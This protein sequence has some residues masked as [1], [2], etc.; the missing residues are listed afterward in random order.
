MLVRLL[1]ASSLFVQD[2]N[3]ALSS[4]CVKK[5]ELRGIGITGIDAY[6]FGLKWYVYEQS[7]AKR[8]EEEKEE[9]YVLFV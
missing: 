2:K 6:L 4:K 3:L 7:S 8:E 9:N 1:A 5:K